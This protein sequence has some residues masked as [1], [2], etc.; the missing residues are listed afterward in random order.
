MFY[1]HSNQ[2]HKSAPNATE[3]D[4]YR[5]GVQFE[6]SVLFRLLHNLKQMS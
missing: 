2:M 3:H 6:I 5:N 1:K 4:F